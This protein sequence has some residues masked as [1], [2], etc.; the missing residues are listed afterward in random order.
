M[1]L[2]FDVGESIVASLVFE[3]ITSL[4]LAR[5]AFIKV[6]DQ[7]DHIVQ[8]FNQ[9][10]SILAPHQTMTSDVAW[11]TKGIPQGSYALQG[12]VAND[13]RA[14]DAAVATVST[15][16]PEMHIYLPLLV[17]APPEVLNHPQ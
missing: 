17:S 10:F 11:D 15:E 14:T 12:H 13:G 5:T 2:Y 9:P 1:V 6:Q 8:D 16:T 3:N 7:A 4:S